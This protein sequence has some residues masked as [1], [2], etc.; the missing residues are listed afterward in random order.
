MLCRTNAIGTKS[1]WVK[2]QLLR[3][4]RSNFVAYYGRSML[5]RLLTILERG[6]SSVRAGRLDSNVQNEFLSLSMVSFQSTCLLYFLH[7][8]SLLLSM[9][10]EYQASLLS[11]L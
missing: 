5:R 1:G 7:E 10:S 4:C 8:L 2:P 3:L 11:Q 6:L 9:L